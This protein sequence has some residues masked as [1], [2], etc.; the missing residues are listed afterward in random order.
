[1]KFC[2]NFEKL[3]S[4]LATTFGSG[5][6]S[7]FSRGLSSVCFNS[8]KF[9]AS[10]EGVGVTGSFC[11]RVSVTK[12]KMTAKEVSCLFTK[13]KTLLGV[14]TNKTENSFS[15]SYCI[16]IEILLNRSSPKESLVR[17]LIESLGTLFHSKETLPIS[18]GKVDEWTIALKTDYER[19][20]KIMAT[21]TSS[22][23]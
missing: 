21:L 9:W 1:M 20:T 6:D 13:C 2:P 4:K 8:W 11:S 18:L 3:W 10:S 19:L 17:T 14:V 23:Y 22:V 16:R 15:P 12:R 7:P 5:F